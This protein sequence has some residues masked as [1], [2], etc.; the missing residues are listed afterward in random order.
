MNKIN[1]EHYE[2]PVG[3][4][5][6]GSY[7]QQLCLCDW[8]HKVSSKS[9]QQ[10]LTKRL[11]AELKPQSDTTIETA[12]EQLQQYFSNTRKRFDLNFLAQGTD[13]QQQVWQ[14]LLTVPFGST[15]SYQTL[16]NQINNPKAVRAVANACGANPLSIFIPCH[17]IIGSNGKLTGYAGG[18]ELKQALLMLE[19]HA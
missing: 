4:L 13:F 2:S 19:Q 11:D 8:S 6:L 12:I 14:A 17:R 10:A 9:A 16:A 7:H 15:I 18:L 3:K 1:I 5:V